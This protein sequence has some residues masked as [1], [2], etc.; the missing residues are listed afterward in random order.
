MT[1]QHIKAKKLEERKNYLRGF[2][3][4]LNEDRFNYWMQTLVAKVKANKMQY[5]LAEWRLQLEVMHEIIDERGWLN[6]EPLLTFN[7]GLN[8]DEALSAIN[9]LSKVS[10]LTSIK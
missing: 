9:E 5:M 7:P 8:A 2:F 4:D 6:P 3:S 1:E 10:Q